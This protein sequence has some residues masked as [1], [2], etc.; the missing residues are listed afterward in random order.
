MRHLSV[1]SAQTQ[2][3]L[4]RCRSQKWLAEHTGVTSLP[5]GNKAIPLNETAPLEGDAAW[6]GNA[7]VDLAAKE[8]T[9]SHWTE[10]LDAEILKSHKEDLP[11]AYETQGDVLIVKIE[12]SVWHLAEM[13]ADAML[14]Q[15]PNIRLVCADQGVQGDF[16]VRRLEPLASRDGSTETV[17]RIKEN[18]Y[19]L[20]VDASK[21]YFSARLS[22]ERTG[23]LQSAKKLKQRL[24]RPLVVADPYAGVG[25]S[26]GVLLSEPGLI[27]GY[28]AGD[29]NPDAVE[30]LQANLTYLVG[31]RKTETGEPAPALTQSTVMC[32][33]AT[34]WKTN[35][36]LCNSSDLLLV[37]L[38]HDSIE[39]LPHLLPLL[40]KGQ[41]SL[42]R[43]WAIIDRA[44]EATE[45][46]KIAAAIIDAGGT[47]ESLQFEEVKGFSASKSFMCFEAWVMLA[48]ESLSS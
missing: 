42:L 11:K 4:E 29:L 35:P 18:G 17:T 22:N 48:V 14:T 2:H 41:T 44:N 24:A 16:R 40:R 26:M 45:K 27:E 30:L 1:P 39:H 7:L 34:E 46:N 25:P 33:D 12:D 38:P 9:P 5:D 8:K 47:I 31:R 10:H 6:L 21:V 37:N 32:A 15:L 19:F 36:H 43:G 20:W 28:H 23:T 13:I 3:W